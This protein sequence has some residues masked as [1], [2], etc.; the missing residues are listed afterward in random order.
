MWFIKKAL[1]PE[2]HNNMDVLLVLCILGSLTQD[3]FREQKLAF[4]LI[5]GI[6]YIINIYLAFA[7]RKQKTTIRIIVGYATLI[8]TSLAEWAITDDPLMLLMAPFVL[9]IYLVFF[10]V[11]RRDFE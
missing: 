2:S 5:I 1:L 8:G 6:V 11:N 4:R 10:F 3:V 7:T 9:L